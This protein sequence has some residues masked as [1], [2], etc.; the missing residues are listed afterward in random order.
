[1]AD[2]EETSWAYLPEPIFLHLS[3]YTAVEDLLRMCATCRNWNLMGQDDY[4]WKR[5]FR[6]DFKVD[7]SI[8]LRPGMSS[9][10]YCTAELAKYS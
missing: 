5:L 7:P 2:A 6:R 4:L 1:M 8:G 10:S 3:A 9:S